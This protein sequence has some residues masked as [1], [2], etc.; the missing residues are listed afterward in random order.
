MQFCFYFRKKKTIWDLLVLVLS[1]KI[2]WK[3]SILLS[4]YW[5]E[6]FITQKGFWKQRILTFL[7]CPLVVFVS[8]LSLLNAH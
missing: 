6:Y 7:Q 1:D 8:V 4:Y 3:Q 5:A 2:N